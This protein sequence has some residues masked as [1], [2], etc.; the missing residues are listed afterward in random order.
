MNIARPSKEEILNSLYSRIVSETSITASLNGT[1]IG[2]LLR[3]VAEELDG[4]WE[5]LED[6]NNQSN[7]TTAT[8]PSLDQIGL[9][10]G[11][12]RKEESKSTTLGQTK[13][14]R[15]TNLSGSSVSIPFSTRVWVS[16]NINNAFFT[17]EGASVGAGQSVD[18]H[19]SAAQTGPAYNVGAGEIDSHNVPNPNVR[20]SNILP[21][22]NGSLQESDD[23]YRERILQGFRRR[24]V[25]NTDNVIA[26]VR[27]VV[28]VKDAVL[29]NLNRGGGT[30]DIIVTPYHQNQANDIV[31][32]CQA[33]LDDA[34]NVGI[35]A[36]V[37][38]PTARNLDVKISLRFKPTATNQ[39]NI[40][41]SVRTQISSLINALPIETGG[42]SSSLFIS[43]LRTIAASS[44]SAVIDASI[45][46]SLD[47]IQ[48]SPDREVNVG[49]GEQIILRTLLVQ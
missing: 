15:F 17:V 30:F 9:I 10:V 37:R 35:N 40:R 27:G 26:L 44:D 33:V 46:A 18:V 6:L 19:V 16:S 25:L 1:V 22:T 13:S 3:L 47:G 41:A 21:I 45:T 31:E 23:S 39:E 2:T 24:N 7:L 42:G 14:I 36:V 38:V 43:Q 12:A 8:G 34:V 20:V 4:I 29:L 32:K 48:L 11:V 5:Y 49:V 28:G